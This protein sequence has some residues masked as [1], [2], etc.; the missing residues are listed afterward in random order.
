MRLIIAS[1]NAHKIAEMEAILASINVTL[2]VVPLREL[3]NDIPDIVEDGTTF[4]ENATKKVETIAQIAPN[5][6][7][8]ADDSGLSINA[9]HGEPGVYSARYAGD[10]DDQANIAKVLNKLSGMPV[11]QRT[12]HFNS[13]IVLRDPKGRKLVVDGQVNGYITDAER[14]HGGFGYDPIFFVPELDKTF[15]EMSPDEKNNISHRGL[16]LKKLGEQLPEW[17][18]GE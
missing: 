16:A 1:N 9:L 15:S 5:D 10:H 13:V 14:G 18:K 4:E 7:I 2:P 12:A 8:L 11:A 3:G 6:Y 17:L